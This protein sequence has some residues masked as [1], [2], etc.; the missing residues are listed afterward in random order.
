MRKIL[1]FLLSLTCLVACDDDCL[2]FKIGEDFEIA[3]NET[4]ENCPKNLS[5]SLLE[6]QD[7]RCPLGG[8][9]IWEGMIVIEGRLRIDGQENK[10]QLSTNQNASGFPQEFSTEDHT[11]K[12]IDVLPYPDTSKPNQTKDQRAILLI[13]KRSS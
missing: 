8:N 12:L 3:L 4:S 13:S 11:I 1:I 5:V 6:I 10:L 9:C 7:S 2:G